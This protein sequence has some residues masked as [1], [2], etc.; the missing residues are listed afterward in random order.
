MPVTLESRVRQMQVFN[1]PHDTYCLDGSC[2]C[3]DTTAVVVEENPRTGQRA[4]RRV[5]RRTSSS[6]TLL[7][8]DR[9]SGLPTGI[10]DVPEVQA[11]IAR[12]RVRVVEQTPTPA[13]SKPASVPPPPAKPAA[14][15]APPPATAKKEG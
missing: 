1:L 8:L 10:L 7:A 14:A 2:S 11:A 13:P 3:S 9:R 12:G 15:P 4:P 6:L 5:T